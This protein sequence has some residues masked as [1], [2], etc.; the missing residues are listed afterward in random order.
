MGLGVLE[1]KRSGDDDSAT[2]DQKDDMSESEDQIP[3]SSKQQR[4]SNV[5][6][7]LMGNEQSTSKKPTIEEM[8][9]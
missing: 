3:A 8:N 2:S 5:M 6:G 7:K 4:D 1:E 9:Q